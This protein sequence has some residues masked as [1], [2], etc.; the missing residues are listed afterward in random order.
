VGEFRELSGGGSNEPELGSGVLG[1]SMARLQTVPPMRKREASMARLL[2]ADS[3][4]KVLH[5]PTT[6][7][8][9]AVGT[10]HFFSYKPRLEAAV[11]LQ[12]FAKLWSK[13]NL[14][15]VA[16]VEKD[17][18][19]D[20]QVLTDV[21]GLEGERVDVLMVGLYLTPLGG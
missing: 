20:G 6:V 4:F 1:L 17:V 8:N 16:L 9:A 12:I 10:G 11:S 18:A 5:T 13:L 14:I 3:R 21:L 2:Q 15:V 19:A 7:R